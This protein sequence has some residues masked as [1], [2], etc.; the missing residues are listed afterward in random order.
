MFF[1]RW[2]KEKQTLVGKRGRPYG[3]VPGAGVLALVPVHGLPPV[4]SA[5]RISPLARKGSAAVCPEVSWAS[6]SLSLFT[7]AWSWLTLPWV[8]SF[9]TAC[10]R[11]FK[12]H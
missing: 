3:A 8:S 1:C 9:T 12:K 6:C 5:A 11:I 2:Y 4:Q 7:S 10:S